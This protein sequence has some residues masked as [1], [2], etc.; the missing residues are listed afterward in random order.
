MMR[1]ISRELKSLS[2]IPFSIKELRSFIR[3]FDMLGTEEDAIV[4]SSITTKSSDAIRPFQQN[5]SAVDRT[6]PIGRIQRHRRFRIPA[7]AHCFGC[8]Q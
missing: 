8:C 3:V 4:E 7:S 6:S 2:I 1:L 5:G